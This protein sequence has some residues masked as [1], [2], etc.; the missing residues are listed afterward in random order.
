MKK[1]LVILG[2]VSIFGNT[3]A[4]VND[5]LKI[6]SEEEKTKVENKINEIKDKRKLQIYVNTLPANEGFSVTDPEKM[7]ILNIKKDEDGKEKI[8]LS[9]SKDINV[10]ECQEGINLVLN[11]AE[12]TL[13]KGEVGNYAVEVL[14]GI[15]G[16]LDKINIEDPIV[17]EQD[18]KESKKIEFF[19]GMAIAF[20]VIFGIIIRVLAVKK[21]RQQMKK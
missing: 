21:K 16:V 13:Y 17:I 7:I 5:T 14:E 1:F 12:R 18:E 4:R 6:F 15:D 3:F 19:G 2:I 9:F 8:E 11:N 10:E 20:F